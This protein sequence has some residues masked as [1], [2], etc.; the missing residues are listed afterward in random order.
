MMDTL[1]DSK[2]DDFFLGFVSEGGVGCD[3]DEVEAFPHSKNGAL[4]IFPVIG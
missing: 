4:C 3:E 1:D 2:N